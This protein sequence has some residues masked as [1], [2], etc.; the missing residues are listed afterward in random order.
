MQKRFVS[1]WFCSLTT[2]WWVR[3]NPGL[4]KVP[5]VL[6]SP[7]HGRMIV[8]AASTAAKEKGV[9]K[10]MV[11][12][13]ARAIIP[14]LQYFDDEPGRQS[15]LLNALAEWC[16]RFTPSVSIE[17]SDGLILDA[18]GCAHLW[19]GEN[20]FL[21][22]ISKRL[23]DF[24]YHTRVAIADTIGAA[25]AVARFGKSLL[26]KKGEHEIALLSLPPIALRIDLEIAAKLEKL[27]LTR[28]SNLINIPK[29]AIQRRFG[30]QLLMRLHQAV[31]KEEEYIQPIL[32]ITLYR[33][34]LPCMELIVS[35]PGIEI[36]LTHLLKNLCKRL[37][38]EEKGLRTALFKCYR[39]DGKIEKAGIGTNHPSANSK[40]LFKL[41][42]DKI[43]SLQPAQ[44]IDLFTLEAGV[45]EDL[46]PSQEKLFESNTGFNETRLAELL[47][48]IG[49]KLG[50]QYIQRFLPCEHY[51]PERSYKPA[52]ALNEPIQ[53]IWNIERPRPLQLL[54]IPEPVQV[55]APVPDYPPMHFRY[56]EILHKVIKADGPER[57]ESEWWLEEGRHR[58]YYC[59]E[60]EE[61]HR[62]WLFRS[63]HYDGAGYK[64]FIHGFFA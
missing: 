42:E 1:I 54:R 58:D 26:I 55:T 17:L 20:E 6:I 41:F 47:D 10:G 23:H 4:I 28:I 44:G 22:E 29:A 46:P 14:G 59:V 13:D 2:D 5:F 30:P 15:K 7:D 61:G 38:Q 35:R 16:I 53:T 11:L 18:T 52:S 63:G 62:Y 27:G 56:K 25:W 43:S 64:W 48:R 21:A 32:P 3:R 39:E 50:A 8:M 60:D 45:V 31:G 49:G 12:A 40:H 33:E 9:D 24:G 57:I 36:A 19:G 37:Q 34:T 51:W